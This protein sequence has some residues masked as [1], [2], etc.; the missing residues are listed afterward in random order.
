MSSFMSPSVKKQKK[1]KIKSDPDGQDVVTRSARRK[2]SPKANPPSPPAGAASAPVAAASGAASAPPSPGAEGRSALDVWRGEAMRLPARA[3]RPRV[4][5]HVLLDEAVS[6][7]RFFETHYPTLRDE[8]GTV[9]RIG[10]D[11][12]ARPG[13]DLTPATGAE[14]LSLREAIHEA[15]AKYVAAPSHRT[16]PPLARIRFVLGEIRATLGFWARDGERD[17]RDVQLEQLDAFGGGSR[18]ASALP[19][20]LYQL[21]SFANAHRAELD[22]LGGFDAALIDEAFALV[23]AA[24]MLP[25]LV[26][27][28]ELPSS[29]LAL[30]NR[31][32]TLLAARMAAV[33]AA[34][35][36]V[37]RG[38][39]DIVREATSPYER[40]RAVAARRAKREKKAAGEAPPGSPAGKRA[41]RKRSR[42]GK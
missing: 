11:S 7:A 35:R 28:A 26:P 21:A 4:P 22:G 30:R 10:L 3:P 41:P 18:S 16:S 8:D 13:R 6:V 31:L 5:L 42:S 20:R 2:P 19:V 17:A 34:A 9:T 33:R 38:S 1:P 14:V 24:T 12:V 15:Q 29:V 40:R 37:F 32:A 23:E 39:P 25:P 36:F 27:E